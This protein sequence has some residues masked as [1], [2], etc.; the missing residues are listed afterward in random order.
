MAGDQPDSAALGPPPGW[1]SDRPTTGRPDGV[2]PSPT[3]PRSTRLLDEQWSGCCR[4]S[5]TGSRGPCRCCT[6]VTVTGSCCTARPVPGRCG[7][8][9]RVRRRSSSVTAIDAL[10]VAPT[11]FESSV[12][13]RSATVR[14]R[15]EPAAEAGPEADARG[16]LR[17]GAARPHAEVRGPARKELAASLAM[18]LVIADDNWLMKAA[19]TGRPPRR[20]RTPDDVWSGLVPLRTVLDEPVAAPWSGT[21]RCPRRCAASATS[22]ES[23]QNTR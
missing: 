13:Y 12:N 16:V 6:P 1:W 10:V 9:P 19:A 5:P 14:G 8:S 20:R 22:K 23:G 4:P 15:L 17:A 21:C 11:T 2:T 18:A 3:A 7:T